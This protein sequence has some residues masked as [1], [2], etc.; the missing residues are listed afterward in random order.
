MSVLD[1]L[2]LHAALAR[3]IHMQID[4]G[5]VDVFMAQAVFDVGNRVAAAEHIDRAR[6]TEAVSGMDME[7]ALWRQHELQIFFTEP[8][9]ARAG[10]CLCAL[11]DKDPVAV[12]RLGGA[13]VSFGCRGSSAHKFWATG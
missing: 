2:F 12:K 8:V 7:Q 1:K 6:V 5:G 3:Q 9:D 10:K 13:A 4:H 11:V